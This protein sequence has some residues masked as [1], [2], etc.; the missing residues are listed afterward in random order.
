MKAECYSEKI[1]LFFIRKTL[2]RWI[3]VCCFLMVHVALLA[4]DGT[5]YTSGNQ[6]LPLVETDI[7]VQR[8][9]LTLSWGED[10][11]AEVDVYY[12]FFNPGERKKVLMGFEANP[13]MYMDSLD[14]SGAHPYISDFTVEMNDKPLSVST[15]VVKNDTLYVQNGKVCALNLFQY[16]IDEA[17]SGN[18]LWNPQIND[19]IPIS[20]VYH[21]SADF[22]PGV[23][24]VRHR[25]RYLMCQSAYCRYELDYKLSPAMR[26]ANHQIDDFTLRIQTRDVP[27]HFMM[28]DNLFSQAIPPRITGTGK[29]RRR[30]V[31]NGNRNDVARVCEYFLRDAVLEYRVRNYRPGA[32]LYLFSADC[33]D[34]GV[35]TRPTDYYALRNRLGGYTE[36]P[37][38]ETLYRRVRNLPFALRGYIFKNKMLSDYFHSQWWYIPDQSYQPILEELTFEEQK[39]FDWFEEYAHSRLHH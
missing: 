8:E 28:E 11:M 6:L 27:L 18:Y 14:R 39:W 23:N 24:V 34:T 20:F 13:P 22:K 25:Y 21:F 16:E 2:L 30:T 19:G 12:E 31:L 29:W 1:R 7:R 33:T 10:G 5:Y 4:N 3:I 17:R 32:E 9:V 35:F 38:T 37:L 26:W 15:S 36:F